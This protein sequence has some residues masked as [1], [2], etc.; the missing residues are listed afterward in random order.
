MKTT[1]NDRLSELIERLGLTPN[2]FATQIGVKTTVIYNIQKG[3]NKPSFDLLQKIADKFNVS[4]DWLLSDN[5]KDISNELIVFNKKDASNDTH[6]DTLNDTH[7][8]KS[9]KKTSDDVRLKQNEENYNLR[10]LQQ[11]Q[12]NEQVDKD[13]ERNRKKLRIQLQKENKDL[14]DLLKLVYY[15]DELLNNITIAFYE[16]VFTPPT[17]V[18]II[19]YADYKQLTDRTNIP[20]KLVDYKDYKESCENIYHKKV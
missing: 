6:F 2:G 4:A 17:P 9:G 5:S 10:H 20:D 19:K 15:T 18:E 3:R 14:A 11:S 12:A 1:I 16:Y 13:G 8:D 7:F